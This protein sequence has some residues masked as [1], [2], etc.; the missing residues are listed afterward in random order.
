MLVKVK[1]RPTISFL[2]ALNEKSKSN[3]SNHYDINVNNLLGTKPF[4]DNIDC[5]FVM[6]G[7]HTNPMV[8]ISHYHKCVYFEIPKSAST[9]V[10]DFL[11]IKDPDIF[12]ILIQ[13]FI[14]NY[15]IESTTEFT[16]RLKSY[17]CLKKLQAFRKIQKAIA[18]INNTISLNSC[19]TKHD[20]VKLI[21]IK[22][23][24]FEPF[25]GRMEEINKLF[26]HY[27]TFSFVRS[28]YN[29][30]ISNYLMFTQQ[31]FRK[32]ILKELIGEYIN[33]EDLSFESF[34]EIISKYKNHHWEEQCKY[35]PIS[36]KIIEVEHLGLIEN[37]EN[38]LNDISTK[39]GFRNKKI[40][41]KNQTKKN[42]S[43]DYFLTDNNIKLIQNLYSLD[44]EILPY[45]I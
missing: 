6:C 21:F 16:I 25:F 44:L 5:A 34:L 13:L 18:L 42:K 19:I 37:L 15:F 9:S 41:I 31:E 32:R 7:C 27:F 2:L 30:V 35:L 14:Q 1:I 22:S 24:K 38:D 11:G 40:K 23:K 43:A 8:W 17:K 10:K 12:Y 20:F 36:N 28:P 4:K 29:R 26:P 45:R 33:F 39:I 3:A